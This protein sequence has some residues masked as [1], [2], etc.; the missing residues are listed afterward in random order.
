MKLLIVEDS[1]RLRKSLSEGLRRMGFAVDPVGDGETGLRFALAVDYD[2]IILDLMLP[3]LDGLTVLQRLREHG[4]N[5]H[6]L[7]LSAKDQVQDRIRGLEWGADDYLVKPFS[8][9]ELLARLKALVRRCYQHH[10]PIIQLGCIELNTALHRAVSG[11]GEVPLT[12]NEL[13]L[14]EYLAL[15][16]GRVV[17]Q[18]SLED[19][20]YDSDTVVTRNA[21]E[22]HI[23]SLR[24]KLRAVGEA[25]LI[26]TRRGFG[27]YIEPS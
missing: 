9:D 17:S 22:A 25:Q 1:E 6:V 4:K 16:R 3:R 10:N 19:H 20:L 11:D 24:K 18:R 21:I 2:V 15:N 13:A 27:Y 8:F 23:S 7:I 12:P 26:K 14:L 5:T